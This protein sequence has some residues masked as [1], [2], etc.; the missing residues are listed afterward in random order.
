MTVRELRRREVDVKVLLKRSALETDTDEVVSAEGVYTENGKPV[1]IYGRFPERQYELEWAV[2]TI[3]YQTDTRTGG[4][5]TTSRIF[6]FRPRVA[7][8]HDFCSATS[9]LEQFPRQHGVICQ[10]G[11]RLTALYR[12]QDPE[13]F[14][15]HLKALEAVR[16]EWVMPESV[17]TSGIVNKNNPLKYHLDSGNFRG[18][19]SCMVV[20]RRDV[21]G[22][23]L[24]VPEFNVRF[25]LDDQAFFLF[26]GQSILHGVTPIEK[27]TSNG[28]RYSI[29]YYALDQMKHCGSCRE[30]LERIRKVKRLREQKRLG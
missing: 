12:E 13:A 30:E 21:D 29:V 5:A 23:Y 2:K 6:G 10:F 9:M 8:R 18:V 20:L 28:Y 27:K 15:H 4:L 11:A 26:D 7:I 17:F 25:L 14:A 1:I 22:G 16:P 19:K 3:D 24:S